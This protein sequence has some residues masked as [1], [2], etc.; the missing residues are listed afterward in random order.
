MFIN[1]LSVF[2]LS[3]SSILEV[4]VGGGS[5]RGPSFQ[6]T[7]FLGIPLKRGCAKGE[8]IIPDSSMLIQIL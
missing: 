4:W 8:G 6:G 5:Y 2:E 1:N 3:L 7:S